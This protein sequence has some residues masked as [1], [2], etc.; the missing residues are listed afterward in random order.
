MNEFGSRVLLGDGRGGV[1]AMQR[2][3]S[4][5]VLES[6]IRLDF[7]EYTYRADYVWSVTIRTRHSLTSL[8][9][10]CLL[11]F[12]AEFLSSSLIS[13]NIKNEINR[14]KILPVVF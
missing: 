3:S 14:T 5:T 1:V 6:R 9:P 7:F 8:C 11:L 4:A 2:R 13:K 12:G 10:E